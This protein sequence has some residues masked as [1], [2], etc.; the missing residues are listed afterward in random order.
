VEDHKLIPATA[1][2][3]RLKLLDVRINPL[4]QIRGSSG[5]DIDGEKKNNNN[6]NT[7][8]SLNIEKKLIKSLNINVFN[9]KF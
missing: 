1:I 7:F 5:L 3:K 2:G 4:N 8:T 6:N 9:L